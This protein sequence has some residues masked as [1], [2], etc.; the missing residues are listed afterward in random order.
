MKTNGT[1]PPTPKMRLEET[2][3][4]TPAISPQ[5]RGKHAQFPGI[6]IRFGVALLHG[7]LRRL[8]VFQRAAGPCPGHR[9][10]GRQFA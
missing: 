6:W 8:L 9:K 1:E 10:S 4:L 5:E 2:L 7:D 3:A